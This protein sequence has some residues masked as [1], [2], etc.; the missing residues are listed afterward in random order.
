[1]VKPPIGFYVPV[2]KIKT[3]FVWHQ[4][5]HCGTQLQ[6]ETAYRV[7][8]DLCLKYPS[9][10][11]REHRILRG[12]TAPIGQVLCLNCADRILG[13]DPFRVKPEALRA[14][15]ESFFTLPPP[16]IAEAETGNRLLR[17]M[18]FAQSRV[19]MPT[20]QRD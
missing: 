2:Q 18:N 10:Y 1:M 9:Q 6:W 16:K 7:S 14:T 11:D 12:Y 15:V 5:A 20:G 8:T 3:A 13:T 17:K 19:Q 4:C